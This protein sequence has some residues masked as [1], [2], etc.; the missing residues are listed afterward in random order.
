MAFPKTTPSKDDSQL[1]ALSVVED[2]LDAAA[3]ARCSFRLLA[4][5]GT[6]IFT[7]APVSTLLTGSSPSAGNT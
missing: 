4:P 1:S 3:L 5:N 6:M 2:A 7:T